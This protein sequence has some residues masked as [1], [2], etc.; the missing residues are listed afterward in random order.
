MSRSV[1]SIVALV[2]SR[3]TR[4]S[5]SSTLRAPFDCIC[6]Q[7]ILN[8][9]LRCVLDVIAVF[10]ETVG[11][12]FRNWTLSFP[13]VPRIIVFFFFLSFGVV[14][15][16][17]SVHCFPATYAL[18]QND[19]IKKKHVTMTSFCIHSFYICRS[20]LLP[21]LFQKILR[22]T[23]PIPFHHAVMVCDVTKCGNVKGA[24]T[25]V[26]RFLAFPVLISNCKWHISIP[27]TLAYRYRRS[28]LYTFTAATSFC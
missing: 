12:H 9:I 24:S 19:T 23:T 2:I 7:G 21:C 17:C 3:C 14:P 26:F 16:S 5:R 18:W 1:S 10:S 25:A 4:L 13:V 27:N 11:I 15:L 28:C 22:Q 8:H 6:T 20:L